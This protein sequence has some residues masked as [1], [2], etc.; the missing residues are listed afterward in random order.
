[1]K[2]YYDSYKLGAY[3]SITQKGRYITAKYDR[4]SASRRTDLHEG[5]IVVTSILDNLYVARIYK[6]CKNKK[7]TIDDIQAIQLSNSYVSKRGELFDIDIAQCTQVEFVDEDNF[8]ASTIV[9]NKN[10][11]DWEEMDHSSFMKY[12][13]KKHSQVREDNKCE[14]CK[15]MD[16]TF[17]NGKW[18]RKPGC[19]SH[20]FYEIK[21]NQTFS[22]STKQMTILQKKCKKVPINYSDKEIFVNLKELREGI[23]TKKQFISELSSLK[24]ELP[25]VSNFRNILWERYQLLHLFL[26]FEC[27]ESFEMIISLPEEL[28]Y[29]LFRKTVKIP[30]NYQDEKRKYISNGWKL[31][32]IYHKDKEVVNTYNNFSIKI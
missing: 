21:I 14:K 22:Y 27:K 10:N 6:I 28:S 18:K 24:I 16:N 12:V 25:P 1:M 2:V 20:F 23:T 26:F 11:V 7:G 17:T 8:Q 4:R 5:D 13:E 30:Q 32:K 31:Y 29:P 9:Y 3:T 19:L 15:R